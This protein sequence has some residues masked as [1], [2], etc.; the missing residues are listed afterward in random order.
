MLV[1]KNR[2]SNLVKDLIIKGYTNFGEN[3]V[4]EAIEKFISLKDF[5][6]KLHLIGPLQTNKVKLALNT[7]DTIQ[8]LDR[9]K[10]IKEISKNINSNHNIKTNDYFI[11]VNIGNEP[12][13]SGV[14]E[15]DLD[16]L[17]NL[18][19]SHELKISGLMCIPPADQ[20]PEIY[21]EKLCNLKEKLNPNLQ[22]SMGMS[23]DYEIAL[24]YNSNIIRIGSRIFK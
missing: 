2:P 12:Q 18:A 15:K 11:Q 22:L 10:L 23:N 24:Q 17:Y 5:K 1:T 6:I 7:F 21:F 8:T 20:K 16:S 13:K 4:Q 14:N 19:L 3:R 9:P